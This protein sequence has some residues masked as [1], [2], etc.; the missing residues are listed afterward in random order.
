MIKGSKINVEL[1]NQNLA[2][3]I[4]KI[5]KKLRTRVVSKALTAYLSRLGPDVV[6]LLTD[7]REIYYLADLESVSSDADISFDL[8]IP[9]LDS[10]MSTTEDEKPSETGH[11][12]DDSGDFNGVLNG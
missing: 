6:D 7:D 3:L 1:D 5:P 8:D 12:G 2:H 10:V 4:R 9:K 11:A